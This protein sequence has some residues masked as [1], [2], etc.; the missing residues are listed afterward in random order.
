MSLRVRI[1]LTTSLLVVAIVGGVLAIFSTLMTRQI[2]VTAQRV[3]DRASAVFNYAI[4]SYEQRLSIETALLADRPGTKNIYQAS[5]LTIDDHLDELTELVDPDWM[6]MTD[7]DGK[8]IG[9]SKEAKSQLPELS[10]AVRKVVLANQQNPWSGLLEFGQ[11]ATMTASQPIIIGDYVQAFLITGVKVNREFLKRISQGSKNDVAMLGDGGV[12]ASTIDLP[13]DS[14]LEGALNLGGVRYITIKRALP[15]VASGGRIEILSLVP[16]SSVTGPFEPSQRALFILLG[17]GLVLSVGAGA[18][19]SYSVTRPL[20]SLFVAARTIKEGNWPE[21]F[22]VPRR[23]EIGSLQGMFAEMAVSLRTS[24]E[25]LVG[26]LEIDPLTELANYRSFREKFDHLLIEWREHGGELGLILIDIDRFQQ[27]NTAYGT[28][29][30]DRVLLSISKFLRDEAGDALCGRYSGNVF[31]AAITNRNKTNRCAERLRQR[32]AANVPATVSVGVAFA[33]PSLDRSDLM[34]LAGELA[35]SQAKAGGRNTIREFS[36]FEY[37]GDEH[38]LNLFLQQGS[39][40]AVRALAE[41]VDA[42]DE[43]T[44]GHSSRVATYARELAE[45]GGKDPG[46]VDLVYVTGTLH[47]V[48]KIGVP[49]SAL[50]KAGPLTE[51]E[52]ALVRMHPEIG[53]K[54]VSKIPQLKDTLAGIRHHHERWDG[55]GYPDRL[56]GEAIPVVARILAVVDAFDAM[57]SERPYRKGMDVEIAIAELERGAGTQFDPEWAARFVKLRRGEIPRKKSELTV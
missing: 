33:N 46:F 28:A 55:G 2:E 32:V 40:P 37:S 21:S 36:G 7:P 44:R 9:A 4:L 39:Y 45:A 50:K 52:F 12:I 49:D 31:A 27:F 15:E 18:W 42:K 53:E 16:E 54:I 25:K 11:N 22:G 17:I 30:G 23:D 3:S 10:E 29:E 1:L 24:R 19:L 26:M 13:T 51:D 56:K 14:R 48:G 35:T 47:D 8:L 41:A 57:T 5:R 38:D 6:V 43:Y 20:N 34:F